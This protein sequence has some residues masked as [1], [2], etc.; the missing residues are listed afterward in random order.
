MVATFLPSFSALSLAEQLGNEPSRQFS[1]SPAIEKKLDEIIIPE[2]KLNNV[3]PNDAFNFL[4][5]Q[6]KA[7]DKSTS[8]PSRK[9]VNI[10][11]KMNAEIGMS[12]V[13]LDLR[14]VPLRDAL[15]Y[16]CELSNAK[17]RVERS[18][19]RVVPISD[20]AF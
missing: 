15:T 10:V 13:A 2:V 14:N 6:A 8:D 9:G 17:F 11:L 1:G 5:E 7:N 19:I 16:I 12:K 4:R 18:A 20:P 3:H